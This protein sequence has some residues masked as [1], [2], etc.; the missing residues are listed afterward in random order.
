MTNAAAAGGSAAT[1]AQR[2]TTLRSRAI[3]LLTALT[4]RVMRVPPAGRLRAAL[5][6]ASLVVRFGFVRRR[7]PQ[8]AHDHR[9]AQ[10]EM[11]APV[12]SQQTLAL[13][14]RAQKQRN[15]GAVVGI[16]G[17]RET[18]Q[19]EFAKR[20][21]F[22]QAQRLGGEPATLRLTAQEDA[23]LADARARRA[24]R[25]APERLAA[26]RGDGPGMA[27]RQR[28]ANIALGFGHILVRAGDAIFLRFRIGVG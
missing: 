18:M 27:A 14:A 12:L 20:V 11:R 5:A 28:V 9:V 21:C 16:D 6:R 13:E 25:N 4:M 7:I 24:Q 23:E 26:V 17:G 8:L 1:K 10:A 22:H 2:F 15:R 19:V 3:R